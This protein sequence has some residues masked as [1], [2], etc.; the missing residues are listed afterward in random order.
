MEL[1]SIR[2]NGIN[3]S[4]GDYLLPTLSAHEISAIARGDP[5]D[6]KQAAELKHRWQCISQASFAPMESIDAKNLADCGW[7]AI[8][9]NGADLEIRNAL[10]PLLDHRKK[11]ATQ[12]NERFYHE[13]TGPKSYRPGETKQQFLARL[14]AGPGPA[15]PNKVP[16]Y[17]LLVGDP[18]EIPYRFQFQLDVQYAVGR[19]H[20]DHLEDYAN[21]ARSVVNAETGKCLLPRRVTFFGVRNSGDQATQ[22]SADHLITPLAERIAAR[23]ADW[24][25]KS[26]LNEDA[27]KARLDLLLRGEDLPALLFCAGHG[28]GFSQGDPRQLPHQGA[29]LCQDWPGPLRW[30]KPIPPDFYFAADDV[31]SD[32]NIHG[33]I[34]FFFACYGAGTPM[35]DEFSQQAMKPRATVAPHSFL[36]RLPQ[37]LLAHPKGGALAVVG[38][39]D[40][41]WG[42]SFVWNRAGEQLGVFESA[43]NRLLNGHPIGSATEYFNQRYAELA[44]DLSMELEEI[45]FGKS[46]DDVELAGMWTA[47][48]DARNY[49]IIGDPAVRCCVSA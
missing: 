49:V 34:A 39:V 40:R 23:Q 22:L 21:Y 5:L 13:F 45:S 11:Q 32:A 1:E 31:S 28:M 46:P 42:Y 6:F 25:I 12:T 43:L 17:L 27:T 33:T 7:G 24:A 10:A 35:M 38:H 41:A 20:F 9:A 2:C 8:F 37:R 3:G 36:A 47:N 19:I 30:R 18:E 14:G 29:L 16:Y 26:I 44:S 4:T 15:D 48:N